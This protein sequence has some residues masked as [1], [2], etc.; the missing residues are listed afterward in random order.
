MDKKSKHFYVYYSYEEFGRGYIGKREC[1]CIPEEDIKYF[2]SFVDKTF[3]PTKKIILETF[4]NAKECLIAE[5]ALHNFYQVDKNPH[6]ANMARQTSTKFYFNKSGESHPN[7]GK[8]TSLEVRK[9][10]SESMMG[11]KNSMY[12]KKRNHSEET[13]QKLREKRKEQIFSKKIQQK[14]GGN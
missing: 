4:S 10:Q 11:E 9:K 2:G 3:R 7:Y 12:G 5:C 6:F 14:S 13:R 8:K 1:K